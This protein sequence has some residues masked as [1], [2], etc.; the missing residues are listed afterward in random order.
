MVL[1]KKT[2]K[3]VRHLFNNAHSEQFLISQ[4]TVS[5]IEGKYRY[6]KQNTRIE[7]LAKQEILYGALCGMNRL[8]WC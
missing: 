2:H 5:K 8:L 4:S 6:F 3:E 1:K 7:L